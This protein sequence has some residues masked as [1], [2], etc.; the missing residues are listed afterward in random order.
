ME[1]ESKVKF[2]PDSKL[3]LIDQVRQVLRYHHYANFTGQTFYVLILR[4][5]K[6]HYS[7]THPAQMGWTQI[8]AF[9]QIDP[10]GIAPSTG[11]GRTSMCGCK[12][13]CAAILTINS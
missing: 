9:S 5:V 10:S 12:L 1:T 3:R 8:D 4:Y 11:K 6:F 7:K 2:K 13:L